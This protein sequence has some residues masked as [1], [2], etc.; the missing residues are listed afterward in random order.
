MHA[1]RDI[2]MAHL[3]V[4][5]PSRSLNISKAISNILR[6]YICI[7]KYTSWGK[8]CDFDKQ[9][10]IDHDYYGSPIGSSNHPSVS[11]SIPS[12]DLERRHAMGQFF[13]A[14]LS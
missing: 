3:T 10:E 9:Y 12:S 2:V 8:I 7:H 1:E 4:R 5:L 6:T 14:D 13:L 11:V